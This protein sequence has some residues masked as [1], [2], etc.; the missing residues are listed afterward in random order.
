MSIE[1]LL[2]ILSQFVLFIIA[3]VLFIW[4]IPTKDDMN[5]RFS[6]MNQRFNDMNQRFNDMSN[7]L[8]DMNSR[9]NDVNSR[10]N[11]LSD[12]VGNIVTG[13]SKQGSP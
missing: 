5:N 3:V 7:R 9:L 13:L 11:A 10:L 1:T 12:R 2:P 6:D 4:K 8:N